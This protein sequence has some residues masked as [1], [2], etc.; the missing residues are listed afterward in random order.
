VFTIPLAWLA[1]PE[2]RQE[3]ERALPAPLPPIPVIYFQPYDG[4]VLWGV[5]AAFT[6]S[7]LDILFGEDQA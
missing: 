6:V 3:V 5:S 7:L 2:N 1:E 4:E